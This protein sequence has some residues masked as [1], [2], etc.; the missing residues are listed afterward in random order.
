MYTQYIHIQC[1]CMCIYIYMYI[2]DCYSVLIGPQNKIIRSQ[3]PFHLSPVLFDF[4]I[5]LVS[6]EF[7]QSRLEVLNGKALNGT[8]GWL[9]LSI[10]PKVTVEN[11][12]VFKV[13]KHWVIL[14]IRG[15][16]YMF[17]TWSLDHRRS[18]SL[19]LC[20]LVGFSLDLRGYITG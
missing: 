5:G 6:L 10:L 18:K 2:T 12:L 1:V 20:L 8:E 15:S 16:L 4:D 3:C 17:I 7:L 14:T 19:L 11:W 13:L 9:K